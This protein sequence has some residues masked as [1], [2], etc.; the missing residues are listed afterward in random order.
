VRASTDG[1]VRHE[2][3][4]ADR[5]TPTATMRLRFIAADLNAASVVEAGVDDLAW[6]GAPSTVDGPP[7]PVGAVAL[8]FAG[9]APN[10][11]AGV[12][13]LSLAGSPGALVDV[14]VHDVRGRLVQRLAGVRLAGGTASITWNG[15]DHAGR[16][17]PAG[18][19]LVRATS[20]GA[21]AVARMVRLAD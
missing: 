12:V 17:L 9:I 13:R 16:M 8:T 1:W 2:L 21:S 20:D 4:V 14:S 18:V 15:R 5:V 19:Y 11:T 3:R 7:P 6:Y 10:P